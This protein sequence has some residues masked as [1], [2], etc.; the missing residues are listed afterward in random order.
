MFTMIFSKRLVVSLCL[1]GVGLLFLLSNLGWV[2]LSWE[3]L[4]YW[5]A[6]LM[7]WGLDL[8]LRSLFTTES[9]HTV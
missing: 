2:V 3:W 8:F 9:Q 7:F 6:L 1:I 4:S 5:P